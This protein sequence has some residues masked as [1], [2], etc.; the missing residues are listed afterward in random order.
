MI[1][2]EQDIAA[3]IAVVQEYLQ[4]EFPHARIELVLAREPKRQADRVF[5]IHDT[6]GFYALNVPCEFLEDTAAAITDY[7]HQWQVAALLREAGPQQV[8]V[9]K[10]GEP[11][12]RGD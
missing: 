7:L 6:A 11:P 3:N 2:E 4:H 8:T 10:K 5:R 1:Q 9:L 12:I